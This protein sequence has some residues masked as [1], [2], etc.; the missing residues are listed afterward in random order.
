MRTE[1]RDLT[2]KWQ[3]SYHVDFVLNIGKDEKV[4]VRS[5]M[6][7][8]IIPISDM[9]LLMERWTISFEYNYTD[10]LIQTQFL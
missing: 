9:E 7:D 8:K 3:S 6:D 10:R 2:M 4:L 1:I 5:L